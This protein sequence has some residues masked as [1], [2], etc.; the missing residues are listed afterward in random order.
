MQLNNRKDVG[1]FEYD[2]ASDGKKCETNEVSKREIIFLMKV[3]CGRM[4]A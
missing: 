1:D 2:T 4:R 3:V